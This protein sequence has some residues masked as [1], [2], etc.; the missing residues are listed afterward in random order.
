M[1]SRRF[2]DRCVAA[3]SLGCFTLLLSAA[4][5]DAACPTGTQEINQ[6]CVPNDVPA[7]LELPRCRLKV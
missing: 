5:G 2:A 7:L 1:F 3:V 6:R 4:C